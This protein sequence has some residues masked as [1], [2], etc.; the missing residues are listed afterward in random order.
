[1]GTD[2]RKNVSLVATNKGTNREIFAMYFDTAFPF[3]EVIG[4]LL[5]GKIY[6]DSV[7]GYFRD[8]G[9]RLWVHNIR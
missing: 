5:G 8:E 6:T 1:M 7:V 3:D 9:H 4:G 2:V